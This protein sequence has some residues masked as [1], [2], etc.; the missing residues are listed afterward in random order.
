MLHNLLESYE[1]SLLKES[2]ECDNIL[3]SEEETVEDD[4]LLEDGERV[5]FKKHGFV[6]IPE[7]DFSDDGT[8]FY[9]Y[10]YNAN[11]NQPQ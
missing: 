11:N 2:E 6:R 7:K 4:M 8:R 1:K 10:I 9:M 5:H 3:V